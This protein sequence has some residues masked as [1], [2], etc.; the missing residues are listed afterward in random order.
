MPDRS[1]IDADVSSIQRIDAVPR[2]LAAVA[3]IT[4]MRFAAVARV[5]E[6]SWTACAV[7]DE[8]G[9]G[10]SPGGDLDVE[11][12]ICNEIRQHRE[13]VVF[14][15]AS[16]H[17]VYAQHH[18][19]KRYGLES[20]VSVPIFRRDGEFFGTLCAIDSR[21]AHLDD[22]VVVQSLQL[23]AELIGMQLELV[24]DLD[25]VQARLKDAQF[26]E[27][28]VSTSEREI[29]DL[30]QPAITSLYM[31]RTSSTLAGQ[32]RQLVQELEDSFD[33]V[34]RLLRQKLDAALGR[35]EMGVS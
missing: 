12:T 30:L 29:R 6:I 15:H 3:R 18:T 7:H 24:E 25:N 16:L 11:T 35:V 33:A 31:L 34:S 23:F 4:G 21:A 19:P 13:P 22:P 27:K 17:P 5:T 9:F 32:D 10:L 1:A 26:R 2:I 28:I 8:L 14:G 20:Y